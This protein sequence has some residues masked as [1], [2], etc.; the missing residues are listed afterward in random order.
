MRRERSCVAGGVSMAGLV[1]MALGCAECSSTSEALPER[2][3]TS[4]FA[5]SMPNEASEA[6]VG[7][8]AASPQSGG[9]SFNRQTLRQVVHTSIAG[10]AARVQFSNAFGTQPLQ[11]SDVHIAQRSAGSSVS[12]VTDRAVT[13]GGQ[14]EVTVTPG[15]VSASDLVDFAVAALSDV[16]IS[17]YLPQSTGPATYHQQGTQTNY[18][19]AG[20]V[21][22]NASLPGAQTTGSYFFLV[23][24][25][26]QGSGSTG[27]V[28]ALGAS[29][30]DGYASDQDANHRWPNYLAVRLSNAGLAVGV[31]NRAS[32][33]TGSSSMALDRVH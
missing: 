9:A 11:L 16:A 19:A 14:T 18:V 26:V 33:E 32:T 21:S 17:V 22:A 6:W 29:I 15:G 4:R 7:T 23:N 28:V 24:L 31:L 10:S 30:T 3:D 2:V 1:L 5:A 12:S 20:D 13:F 8:W 25:D 27:S